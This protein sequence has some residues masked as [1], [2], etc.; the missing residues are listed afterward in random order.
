LYALD[1]LHKSKIRN[2]IVCGRRGPEHVSFTAP[3]L[4]DL[5]KLENTDVIIDINEIEKAQ[6]RME[7]QSEIEKELR[8]NLEAMRL[9]AENEKKGV[10]RKLE[11]KFF[12]TPIEIRGN[13]KV[14]EVFFDINQIEADDKVVTSGK[15]FSIKC[16]LVVTAIGYEVGEFASIPL[17]N[18][19][20]ANI[21]GKVEHNLYVVG[22][23]KRGP[24]GVIGTNKSDAADVVE[25]II[26]ELK[27]PKNTNGISDLLKSG[28]E[29]IDQNGWERINASEILSGEPY[30]KPRIKEVDRKK[31]I[32]LSK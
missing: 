25:L 21:G 8:N 26:S 11:I 19:R 9:I 22:W 30:G 3:E 27:E 14:E 23:A 16:G 6:K 28:H 13:G 31:M 4:R 24:V 32:Q 5:P 17:E 12:A 2:V 18:G 29:V 1:K 15:G 10:E 7:V 20:I